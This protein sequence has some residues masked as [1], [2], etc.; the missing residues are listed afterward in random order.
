MGLAL[1]Y[2]R[3]GTGEPLLLIHGTGSSRKMWAPVK[4]LL[5]AERDVIAVDLPGH[6]D[7]PD[8]PAGI[9]PTPPGY[10][11]VVGGFLDDLGLTDVH[12]AGNSVGGWTALELGKAGRARSVVALAP[13]G[14]WRRNS[15][16]AQASLRMTRRMAPVMAR[17]G[18]V[19]LRT[20]VGR[21]LVLG[22]VVGRPA[23]LS[24][25]EGLDMIRGMR[26]M[27]GFDEHIEAVSSIRFTGG[28][29]IRVP[30]TVAFGDREHL[31]PKSSRLRDE[32]PAHTRWIELPR[33]G[34]VPTW[35]D[36][37]LIARTILEG[38]R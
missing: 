34:H 4:A 33:C 21:K 27:R 15:R 24:P 28:D 38:A 36:P 26:D 8:L 29:Q 16:R 31:L 37:A 5:A 17:L 19:A 3:T 18:K 9:V 12:V 30:V 7:S 6:G 20:G 14:L 2:D 10:A 13:A 35:D 32:L 22:Q 23:Q 25:D 1:A 11:E